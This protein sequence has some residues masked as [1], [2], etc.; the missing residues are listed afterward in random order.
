MSEEKLKGVSAYTQGFVGR[1]R[2]TGGKSEDLP[3]GDA[4]IP[5]SRGGAAETCSN[6]NM[7]SPFSGRVRFGMCVLYYN[8]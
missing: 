4:Q 2:I 5:N 8:M 3:T 6:D 1:H 7:T